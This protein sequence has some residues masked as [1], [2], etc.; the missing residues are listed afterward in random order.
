[1]CGIAGIVAADRLQ[2]DDRMRAQAMRDVLTH[3]GPD[4]AGLHIDEQAALAHRRLSI[5]DLAGGHQPLGNEDGSIWVTY[6]GEIY[7]HADVRPVLE[8]AGHRYRTRSDTETIVHAYEEWGDDCIERFRG[9][10]AFALW[11]APRKR[12]LL[13]RDRLGVKPLYWALVENRLLFASEIKA[14]LESGLVEARPNEAVISEVLA[15]RYTSSSETLFKGI[16][17]LLPGHRLVF[18]N[19]RVQL[20]QYWDVPLDGPDP[21]VARLSERDI[22]ARFRA[23]LQDSVRLRLMADVPLGMFLS[24][25][26]DSSAVAALMT[27]EM[28]RPV[29]TFSV[30]FADRAFSELEYARQVARAVGANAHEIVIDDADFFGAL[31]RLVWHEDEPIAHPS[32][33]P[34]HFVSALAR[35]HVKVVLTGEGSDELLAGYGK[36]PRSLLNW[37][38]GGIYERVVP[39]AVRTSIA[40]SLVPRLPLRLRRYAG[41]SFLA[42]PRNPAAMFFDTFAG[43]PLHLQR[44]LLAPPVVAGANTYGP[45][46]DYFESSPGRDNVLSALLY[47]DLKTY[48]VELLMKQDQMSMSTSIESRVPFLDHLLV[49]F[50]A[51]LPDHLKLEGFTTKRILRQAMQGV[52]PDAILSRPKMGFPVPFAEWVRGGWNGVM[53]EV[54]LDRR[55]RERGLVNTASVEKLLDAHRA[56]ARAG[57]DAIW[58]LVNLELWYRT[59]IDGDGVQTLP[60]PG[61]VKAAPATGTPAPVTTTSAG[62]GYSQPAA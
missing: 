29:E 12:L 41:R 19:G 18:E 47:T 2:A 17:K 51:R 32:S 4:G 59:F 60:A 56:G 15:T 24:G 36:Y 48:L 42:V 53:R 43:V 28:H 40:S 52:I 25:G 1:M 10:F 22:V 34:L 27:K 33:V 35:E 14:I 62:E 38:A 44:E 20:T 16:Y 3:R 39:A 5:V 46:L 49:E 13:V 6:N 45:S 31:P 30:A 37:K 23:L 9:M 54:L 11:D 55:T 50:A 7:N 26:I 57:G 21:E 8:L 58:A 61:R